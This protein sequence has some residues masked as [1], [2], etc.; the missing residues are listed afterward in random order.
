MGACTVALRPLHERIAAHVLAAERL[1]GDDTPVPVLAKGKTATAR[2]WV[3][4]RDDAPF[5]GPDPPAA[6]FRYSRDRSGDHPVEHLRTFTGILQ[7]DIYAGYNRLYAAG[8]SPGPVTEAACWSHCWRKF[9]ELADIAASKGRGK[10]APPISPLALEAVKR[11]DVLF[12]I[13]RGINGK[14]AEQRLAVRERPVLADLKGWMLSRQRAGEPGRRS[15]PGLIGPVPGFATQRDV[16]GLEYPVG[17]PVIAHGH[18]F[19]ARA[20]WWQEHQCD[21]GW[22]LEPAGGVPS[23]PVDDEYSVSAWCHQGRDFIKMPC[24]A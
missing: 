21:V 6:L 9:F 17:K 18:M 8:R 14:A 7:A 20:P 11:I 23:G 2:V 4:V 1:H 24:M 12:D 5:G 3:Y 22:D 10:N 13:E 19:S 15:L 16:V